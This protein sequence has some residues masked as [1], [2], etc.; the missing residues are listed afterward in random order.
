MGKPS[1]YGEERECFICHNPNVHRHH[2]YYGIG[3]RQVSE[4][5]GCTVFLCPNHHNMSD[6][7]VHFDKSLDDF[8]KEDCQRRWERREGVTG[9]E[10]FTERFGRSYL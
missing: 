9:H 6:F 5:E 1:L 10:R 8:F 3:R 4:E 2:I 7:G